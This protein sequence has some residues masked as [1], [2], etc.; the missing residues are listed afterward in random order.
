MYALTALVS[1]FLLA[2]NYV[3]FFYVPKGSGLAVFQQYVY[4]YIIDV[5]TPSGPL[6]LLI[7]RY[8]PDNSAVL[9]NVVIL[10]QDDEASLLAVLSRRS[11]KGKFSS[12]CAKQTLKYQR[13][14]NDASKVFCPWNAY[15]CICCKDPQFWEKV[16]VTTRTSSVL[17]N[18]SNMYLLASS[19]MLL[20]H[21][22]KLLFA[23][24]MQTL[25]R[26]SCET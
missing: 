21:L 16:C 1:Q 2:V 19:L 24:T 10:Q 11:D 20:T 7:T 4:A 26:L 5:H 14:H 25:D 6:C 18:L 17:R 8:N 3:L 23:V 12:C 13:M 9:P 22:H 15:V